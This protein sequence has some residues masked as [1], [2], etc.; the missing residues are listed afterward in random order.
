MVLQD[1]TLVEEYICQ[2]LVLIP[3]YGGKLYGIGLVEVLCNTLSGILNQSL[4]ADIG[5]HDTLHGL[6][7]GQGMGTTSIETKPLQQLTV[8]TEAVL[9]AI[10]L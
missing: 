2:K 8:R 9:Y 3:E 6:R 4:T 5:F 7:T 10:F 1:W